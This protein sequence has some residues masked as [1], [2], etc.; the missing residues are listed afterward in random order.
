MFRFSSESV[1]QA[2]ERGFERQ[3]AITGERD[4]SRLYSKQ[5][6]HQYERRLST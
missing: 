1:A 5:G 2:V 3:W 6:T 4:L